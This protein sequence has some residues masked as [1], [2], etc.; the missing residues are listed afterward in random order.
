MKAAI[1]NCFLK[2]YTCSKES[3]LVWQLKINRQKPLHFISLN[4]FAIYLLDLESLCFFYV[5]NWNLGF[6]T[7]NFKI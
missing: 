3:T 7:S 2:I 4:V 6:E 5:T 1:A